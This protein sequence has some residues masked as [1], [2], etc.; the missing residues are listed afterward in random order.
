DGKLLWAVEQVWDGTDEGTCAR[1]RK[2]MA[3]K[4]GM[5]EAAGA[6]ALVVVSGRKFIQFV[7]Y[8]VGETL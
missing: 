8:E 2:H 1:I 4:N 3:G 5:S 7:A 6:E